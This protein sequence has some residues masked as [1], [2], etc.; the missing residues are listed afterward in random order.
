MLSVPPATITWASPR[1][2]ASRASMMACS[3]DPQAMLT[4]TAV[5][6]IGMPDRTATWRATL[7]PEPA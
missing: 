3:P 7:G 1:S 2:I 5:D 6:V 4:V